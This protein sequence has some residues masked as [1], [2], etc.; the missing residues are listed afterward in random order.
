MYDTGIIRGVKNWVDP[1]VNPYPTQT[2]PVP[3]REWTVAKQ[4][5]CLLVP[6]GLVELQTK[7]E[8]RPTLD[9]CPVRHVNNDP[10]LTY[11]RPK[12][13][14]NPSSPANDP[15]K[16]TYLLLDPVTN[17][18]SSYPTQIYP[19]QIHSNPIQPNPKSFRPTITC[20]IF[21]LY[22]NM[23]TLFSP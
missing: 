15:V 17:R 23:I 5:Q 22:N 9:L 13:N 2:R 18:P 6:I 20:Y 19:N 12:T 8:S 1:R 4:T 10:Y 3:S 11:S 21:I 7:C 16:S 14:S